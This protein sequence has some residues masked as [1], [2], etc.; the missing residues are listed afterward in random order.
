MSAENR[1]IVVDSL[2]SDIFILC[3]LLKMP[4]NQERKL[5]FKQVWLVHLM[6]LI[7]GGCRITFLTTYRLEYDWLSSEY[8]C[9]FET[10][11]M[12]TT[13]KQN[14]KRGCMNVAGPWI[15]HD[16]E[17]K[18][19]SKIRLRFHWIHHIRRNRYKVS[20]TGEVTVQT[21]F[22]PWPN[23]I[24]A[25]DWQEDVN[26]CLI[27]HSGHNVHILKIVGTGG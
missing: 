27:W 19:K 21:S 5:I 10:I 2:S 18:T 13:I 7:T 12:Q 25:S 4:G 14:H 1:N 22:M 15:W 8:I 26:H 16:N 11:K 20:Y 6:S 24:Y 17:S 23:K 9:V 3:Q